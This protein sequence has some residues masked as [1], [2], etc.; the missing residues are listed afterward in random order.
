MI[1]I[2]AAL[3]HLHISINLHNLDWLQNWVIDPW[4]IPRGYSCFVLI[5]HQRSQCKLTEVP[6]VCYFRW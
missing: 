3:M 6:F 5:E 4:I 2:L 1:C